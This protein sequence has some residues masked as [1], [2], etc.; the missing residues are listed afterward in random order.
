MDYTVIFGGAFGYGKNMFYYF[1]SI[2]LYLN[3]SSPILETEKKFIRLFE[4]LKIN[5]TCDRGYIMVKSIHSEVA[6]RHGCDI[7]K[8]KL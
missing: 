3:A 6:D 7:R 5:L 2:S 4:N 1:S 8:C